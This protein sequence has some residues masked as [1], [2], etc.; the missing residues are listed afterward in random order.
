MRIDTSPLGIT[1]RFSEG[2]DDA[3]DGLW[4]LWQESKCYCI[5]RISS[6]QSVSHVRCGARVDVRSLRSWVTRPDIQMNMALHEF[7][8]TENR[9]INQ[10]TRT[11]E[12]PEGAAKSNN[13]T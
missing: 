3:E 4:Y 2:Y 1:H 8:N 11:R 10:L 5:I 7:Q 13:G 6:D 12:G 9:Y